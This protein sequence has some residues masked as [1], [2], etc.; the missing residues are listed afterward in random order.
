MPKSELRAVTHRVLPGE[1]PSQEILKMVHAFS[2]ED[3]KTAVRT[4]F[5]KVKEM[6]DFIRDVWKGYDCDM[7]G[8]RYNTGCRCCKAKKIM[9]PY[10]T[11]NPNP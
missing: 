1:K 2:D 6:E 3:R 7:D 9:E 4:L 10:E 8:H 5:L 11:P